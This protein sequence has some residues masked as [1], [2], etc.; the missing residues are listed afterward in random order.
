MRTLFGVVGLVAVALLAFAVMG[1][2]QL[3]ALVGET[4]KQEPEDDAPKPE[5]QFIVVSSADPG[6]VSSLLGA[7]IADIV[8][9]K[10]PGV[11]AQLWNTATS[12]ESLRLVGRGEA[13]MGM[14]MGNVVF[15]AYMG[16]GAF[17]NDKQPL[18]ALFS[19]YPS[20]QHLVVL[21]K[22]PIRSIQ[23][24]VG[25][26]VSVDVA[27]SGCEATSYIILEAAGIRG[28]VDT[29]NYSQQEAANALKDGIVD[30]V[31]YNFTYPC[32]A[33]EE[34]SA[35]H[36]IRLIPLEDALLEKIIGDYPYFAKGY[37]PGKAYSKVPGDTRA[38]AVSSVMAC[39]EGMDPD[40]AYGIVKALYDEE[41]LKYLVG[42]HP[43]AKQLSPETGADTPIP[44]HPGAEGYFKE[45]GIL[46]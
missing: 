42:I 18:R 44:L 34:I 43:V 40:L 31:F 39:H 20:L 19:M 35:T 22:S 2:G 38:L 27:G 23:D 21:D 37:I 46:P 5:V 7:G 13:D 24:L 6:S 15:D 33:V 41:S 45:T 4:E 28:Q 9:D 25:K 1:C 12:V 29:V 30:A 36:A 32:A 10:V 11:F 3:D 16:A 14:A 8:S 17:E 26:K